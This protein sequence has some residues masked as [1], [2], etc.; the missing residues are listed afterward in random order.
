M[1][2]AT[3]EFGFVCEG[4]EA[5]AFAIQILDE[6]GAVVWDSGVKIMPGRE[7][8]TAGVNVRRFTAP[9]Y[10]GLGGADGSEPKIKDGTSYSW[11]VAAFNAAFP[12]KT[13]TE[14]DWSEKADFKTDI[15]NAIVN[16]GQKRPF[17]RIEAAVRYYGP[18]L[19]ADA[20]SIVVEDACFA[21]KK[22]CQLLQSC[23]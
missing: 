14:D 17:G 6:S 2:S 1:Y 20:G 13:L 23:V 11:R 9:V 10:V 16:P 4:G 15:A 18:N 22:L 21:K 5:T 3:P 12:L 7:P 19:S 8:Y